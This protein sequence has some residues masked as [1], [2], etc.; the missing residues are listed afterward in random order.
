MKSTDNSNLRTSF[1][2]NLFNSPTERD[3]LKKSIEHIPIFNSLTKKELNELLEITHNRTYIPGEIIFA[4]GDVGIGLYIIRDGEV[5]IIKK[6]DDNKELTL[7]SLTRG[8]FFGEMA[9][10]DNEKRSASAIAKTNCRI[11][12]LF[13]PDIDEF[14]DKYPKSGIK[15]LR[16]I[17]LILAERL[18][19]INEEYFSLL[20]KTQK[21]F[22]YEIEYKK[23]SGSN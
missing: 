13:K 5:E 7:A 23:D 10:I 22:Q 21:G 20:I 14:I 16:G 3:D 2:T 18:R 9:L 19:N 17:S 6:V 1:W 4:Q 15:I 11:S 12:V 8:D